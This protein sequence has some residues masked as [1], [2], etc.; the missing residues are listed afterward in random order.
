MSCSPGAWIADWAIELEITKGKDVGSFVDGVKRSYTVVKKKNEFSTFTF[1]ADGEKGYGDV[2]ITARSA[3]IT[4]VKGFKVIA[5]APKVKI[6]PPWWWYGQPIK[7]AFDNLPL[8]EFTETHTPG[9]GHK[10]EPVI[11]WEPD[12]TI[13]TSNYFNLVDE[14]YVK[15]KAEN[16]GGV[17]RDSVKLVFQ[18]ECIKANF[19][20]EELSPGDTARLS[21]QRIK[22]DGTPE[23]LP[24]GLYKFSV[25]IVAG[26]D[27]S[28]GWFATEEEEPE[29]GTT[30]LNASAQILY[31]APPSIPD[32]E[33]KVRVVASAWEVIWWK[34]GEVNGTAPATPK[35]SVRQAE[36]EQAETKIRGAKPPL[37]KQMGAASLGAALAS[38]WCP[39]SE[40]VVK[41]SPLH[42]FLVTVQPDTIVHGDTATVYV[43]AKDQDDQDVEPPSGTLVNVIL[44]AAEIHGNLQYLEQKG[45]TIA[46]ITYPDVKSGRVK[47]IADGE[48]PIETGLQIVPV[49]VTKVREERIAGTG[50]VLITP[51]F[52]KFC[53]GDSRW[54]ATKYDNYVRKNKDGTGDSTDATGNKVYH[55]VGS[56]G[57]ALTCLAMVARAG[58]ADIDPGTLAEYMNNEKHYGFTP[59]NGVIW[60]L[61]DTLPGN[62]V[63]V[64][65]DFD[66]EC[67]KYEDDVITIDLKASKSVSLTTLDQFLSNGSLIV[68]QVYNRS[69]RNSNWVLITAKIEG[70]YSILDPGCYS[71]RTNLRNGYEGKV[72]RYIVY[73]RN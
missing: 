54:A 73:S 9:P 68:A 25:M 43:Q 35:L 20:P 4:V 65:D 50:S 29:G 10:F 58:G 30:L 6:V 59:Q 71:G 32:T 66:G 14:L 7:L 15:V 5:P 62:G 1:V 41:G 57:C 17:A 3:G 49:G 26:E 39:I 67:L 48:N 64:Y 23:D 38:D 60:N 28:K 27:S 51:L 37:A 31:I 12:D 70:E 16:S 69:T 42:H 8:L 55:T 44:D 33:M 13:N 22:E 24:L 19:E 11:T 53:Q 45:K 46:D 56:K 61:T 47:F 52:E 63:F 40:V 2:E 18:T 72:F 36:V 21:F 34:R